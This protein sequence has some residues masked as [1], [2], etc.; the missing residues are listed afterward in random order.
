MTNYRINTRSA[1][2]RWRQH[3]TIEPLQLRSLPPYREPAHV[4]PWREPV[5]ATPRFDARLLLAR[6]E[7]VHAIHNI[8]HNV[9]VAYATVEG[10]QTRRGYCAAHTLAKDDFANPF[11][12]VVNSLLGPASDLR[13]FNHRW[14]H[15]TQDHADAIEAAKAI[16][17]N[18]VEGILQRAKVA[19]DEFVRE[20]EDEIVM[21]GDRLYRKGELSGLAMRIM[22]SRAGAFPEDVSQNAGKSAAFN[23]PKRPKRKPRK[24]VKGESDDTLDAE[25]ADQTVE[26]QDEP[27]DNEAEGPEADEFT[28]QTFD[29]TTGHVVTKKKKK[30]I[31]RAGRIGR[32]AFWRTDGFISASGV[33]AATSNYEPN[34]RALYEKAV[35]FWSRGEV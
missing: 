34:E 19:A 18:D 16:D 9:E 13:F 6:H 7:A 2:D 27:D 10:Q 25:D 24:D 4:E 21:I 23:A 1:D 12:R 26:A 17:E 8:V 35:R 20:Y 32:D 30:K 14:D 31:G 33:S 3:G 29:E 22:L 11:D 28:Y 5:V 15:E